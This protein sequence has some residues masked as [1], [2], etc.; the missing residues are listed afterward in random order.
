MVTDWPRY[1]REVAMGLRTMGFPISAPSLEQLAAAW[2]AEREQAAADRAE[3]ANCLENIRELAAQKRTSDA[4][5]ADVREELHIGPGISVVEEAGRVYAE[6]SAIKQT[7]RPVPDS[8]LAEK[9]QQGEYSMKILPF[10]YAAYGVSGEPEHDTSGD[11]C[12]CGAEADSDGV[13][14]HKDMIGI[15]SDARFWGQGEA[16]DDLAVTR[17]ALAQ[18]RHTNDT[19]RGEWSRLYALLSGSDNGTW[20]AADMER[21]IEAKLSALAQARAL[22]TKHAVRY[23]TLGKSCAECGMLLPGHDETCKIAALAGG[24]R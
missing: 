13:V 19:E 12:W 1:L 24:A 20:S 7:I 9:N 17:A 23:G 15:L 2:D 8:L 18:A 22:L 21:A 16:A 6:L 11:P 14:V 10:D 4:V 3:I 5:I